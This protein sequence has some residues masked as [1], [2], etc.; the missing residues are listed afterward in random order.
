M[1]WKC[2]QL[3]FELS[4]IQNVNL[5][6]NLMISLLIIKSSIIDTM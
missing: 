1:N 3:D 6:L 4:W 5:K 2:K